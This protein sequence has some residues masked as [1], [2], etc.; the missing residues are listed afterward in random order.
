MP[1]LVEHIDIPDGSRIK[2][3]STGG[4]LSKEWAGT[5]VFQGPGVAEL[6]SASCFSS[7]DAGYYLAK[8]EDG[9][10]FR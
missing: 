7:K 4:Y 6:D 5:V 9:K 2:V 1:V 3:G 8:T 10:A